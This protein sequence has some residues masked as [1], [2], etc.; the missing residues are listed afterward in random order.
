M[1]CIWNIVELVCSWA[2]AIHNQSQA[3]WLIVSPSDLWQPFLKIG[4]AHRVRYWQV[5]NKM[6]ITHVLDIHV[7]KHNATT[8][9]LHRAE[10]NFK[11][12]VP[13]HWTYHCKVELHSHVS[14]SSYQTQ[15]APWIS[16]KYLTSPGLHV[17]V[18]LDLE[19][20]AKNV[21]RICCE[22]ISSDKVITNTVMR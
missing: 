11:C 12:F 10:I 21:Q 4:V 14:N 16:L 15:S 7:K 22:V 2:M 20:T 17:H 1:T 6:T 19:K 13:G 5:P 18:E 8:Q 3:Y 9:K